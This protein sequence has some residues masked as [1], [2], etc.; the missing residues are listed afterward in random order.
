MI[1]ATYWPLPG[2]QTI[3]EFAVSKLKEQFG[4]EGAFR[5]ISKD[6]MRNQED[7]PKDGLFFA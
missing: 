1:L 4:E 3:N 7:N 5:L 6:E 2:S